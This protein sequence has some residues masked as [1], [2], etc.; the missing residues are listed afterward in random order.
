MPGRGGLSWHAWTMTMA[1]FGPERP[2]HAS[3]T[4]EMAE[5]GRREH[6]THVVSTRRF[7]IFLSLLVIAFAVFFI[8]R[9]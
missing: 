1:D 5:H 9:A 6:D 3:E 7:L 4:R 2:G 8:A